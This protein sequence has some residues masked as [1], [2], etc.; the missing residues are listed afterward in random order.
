MELRYDL[1]KC[2]LE[3]H[4][5]Q[6][7]PADFLFAYRQLPVEFNHHDIKGNKNIMN[8]LNQ[9]YKKLSQGFQ[10]HR[11]LSAYLWRT[12]YL[13][14]ITRSCNKNDVVF[15]RGLKKLGL[16]CQVRQSQVQVRYIDSALKARRQWFLKSDVTHLLSG[17][18]FI[19]RTL[20]DHNVTEKIQH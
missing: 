5:S 6:V 14:Q 20:P 3:P 7:C 18:I 1:N 12:K 10:N 8:K 2:P 4:I 15:V 9:D 16:V 13:G 11:L 17:S 19:E